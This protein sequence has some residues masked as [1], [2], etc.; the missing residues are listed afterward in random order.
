VEKTVVGDCDGADDGGT[1]TVGIVVGGA[2]GVEL[3]VALGDAD[4]GRLG[5]AL[6][7]ALGDRL[8][9]MVGCNVLGYGVGLWLGSLDGAMLGDEVGAIEGCGEGAALVGSLV[10]AGTVINLLW[11]LRTIVID[12]RTIAHNKHAQMNEMIKRGEQHKPSPAAFFLRPCSPSST[13]TS[14]LASPSPSRVRVAARLFV[15]VL[16]LPPVNKFHQKDRLEFF[17]C[18][19]HISPLSKSIGQLR[20]LWPSPGEG[21]VVEVPEGELRPSRG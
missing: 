5:A 16:E 18:S 17:C 9:A 3:G 11:R 4:G 15:N 1:D 10:G 21:N 8:G 14:L 13:P 6:G 12:M 20:T 19:F 2:L 7:A